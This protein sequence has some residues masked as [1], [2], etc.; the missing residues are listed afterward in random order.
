M[1]FEDT[2][3][4][5]TSLLNEIENNRSLMGFLNAIS[6][7]PITI[8]KVR[9]KGKSG[10]QPQHMCHENVNTFV[11]EHGGKQIFGWVLHHWKLNSSKEYDGVF[12]AIF[13]S[14]WLTP[15]NNLVSITPEDTD[16]QLFLPDTRRSFN[17]ANNESYN[18]RVI[19]L[20]NYDPPSTAKNPTRNVT[21]FR[22]GS[23][24]ERDKFF[25][26]YRVPVSTEEVFNAVPESM[27]RIFNGR[28]QLT[29]EGKKWAC[30]RFSVNL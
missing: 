15:E 22:A 29:E 21:F 16:F 3:E 6:S 1:R 13:H 26:K 27:K 30:L 18:N 12:T 4:G 20:D 19:F 24:I 28:Y 7:N 2:Q 14:N 9:K 8:V 17:F 25:E 23:Y 11:K 5:W 10:S